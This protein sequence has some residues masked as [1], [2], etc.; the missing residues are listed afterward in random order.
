MKVEEIEIQFAKQDMKFV[1]KH[2]QPISSRLYSCLLLVVQ[3]N[4]L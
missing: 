2:Y 1:N 3:E 4:K